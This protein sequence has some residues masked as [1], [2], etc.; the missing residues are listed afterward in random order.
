MVKSISAKVTKRTTPKR[1]K[2]N[3]D[4]SVIFTCANFCFVGIGF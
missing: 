3:E 1:N 4:V 2:T